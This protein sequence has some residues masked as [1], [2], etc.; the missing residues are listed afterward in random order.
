MDS[1]PNYDAFVVTATGPFDVLQSWVKSHRG[2]VYPVTIKKD[3]F[4]RR[5]GDDYVM[6]FPKYEKL[7]M[8]SEESGIR[9]TGMS[10]VG[11]P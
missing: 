4:F 8:P 11:P 2:F 9:I 10:P 1:Q 5:P 3:P 6:V 7:L